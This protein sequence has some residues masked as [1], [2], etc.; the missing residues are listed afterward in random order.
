MG[1]RVDMGSNPIH[2]KASEKTKS[3]IINLIN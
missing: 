3:D 1:L 2:A